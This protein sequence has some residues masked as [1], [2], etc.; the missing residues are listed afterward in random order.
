MSILAYN[1]ERNIHN[2][3]IYG[4]LG[5]FELV[6][7]DTTEVGVHVQLKANESTNFVLN[8]YSK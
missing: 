1:G 7:Q 2:E 8:Y 3:F 4:E 6:I 5:N